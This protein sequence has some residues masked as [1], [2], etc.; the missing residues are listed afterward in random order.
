MLGALA[1]DP[2]MDEK[3]IGALRAMCTYREATAAAGIPWR[4]WV[5]W[6]RGVRED[7]A[8]PAVTRL[9]TEARKAYAQ[10]SVAASARVSLAGREDWK[11]AAWLLARRDSHAQLVLARQKTRAE[12]A[13]IK[14]RAGDGVALTDPFMPAD[15][16]VPRL[17]EPK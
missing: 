9:V 1:Y 2:A 15:D 4:T 17:D 11:A 6:C 14:T 5:H 12:T 13:A 3:V 8:I 7:N 16:R 10:A